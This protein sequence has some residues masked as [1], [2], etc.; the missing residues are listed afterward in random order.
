MTPAVF[1]RLTRQSI[2]AWFDDGCSSMGAAIAYY[3]VFSIAPVLLI[4]IKVAGVVWGR[5]AV[6]GEIVGQLGGLIGH[7]GAVAVQAVVERAGR[8]GDGGLAGAVG[9]VVLL[10]G[11]TTVFAELQT[12]LDRIWKSDSVDGNGG[13]WSLI[14]TRLLSFGLVLGLAFVMSA[15]LVLSTALAVFGRWGSGVLPAWEVLLQGANAFASV[16]V[17]TLLFA[18]IYR[19]MPR[20]RVAWRDVWIGALVTAALFEI[21]KLVIGL[22]LGKSSVTSSY[23][24][25]GSFIV[26]LLWVYYASQVFLLGAEFTWVYANSHGSRCPQP[27]QTGRAATAELK[28]A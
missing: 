6:Q 23:A 27:A 22:Y 12:S 21:G 26:L 28:R 15:S 25:A 24:A 4:V 7:E 16:L 17:T 18:M 10:I 1:A 13:I 2:A 9:G 3:T 5:E 11:A 14:R 19:F 20:A 8:Q